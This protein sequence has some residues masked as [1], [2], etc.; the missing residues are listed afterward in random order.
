MSA[1]TGLC[2]GCRATGIPTAINGGFQPNATYFSLRSTVDR[3]NN[4]RLCE[5]AQT[6]PQVIGGTLMA[7]EFGSARPGQL[8]TGNCLATGCS[9]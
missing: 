3:R 1:R 5:R 9:L 8:D 4:R 6:G 2:G 7:A